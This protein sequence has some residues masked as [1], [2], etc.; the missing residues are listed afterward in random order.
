MRDAIPPTIAGSI[1][2][3]GITTPSLPIAAKRSMRP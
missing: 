3:L 2:G 1:E